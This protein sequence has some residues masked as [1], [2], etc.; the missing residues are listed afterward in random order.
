VALYGLGG[1]LYMVVARH[2]IFRLGERGLV[3][4]GVSL[5]GFSTLA[6]AFAPHWIFASPA[7]LIGGFGFFMFHNTM[8]SNATQMVA[9]SRGTAV[10]LFASSL[11]LGQSLGV[12]LA[13]N[14]IDRVGS[15]AVVAMGGAMM[16]MLGFFF[17]QAL[18]RRDA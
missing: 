15:T 16:M 6:L 10:S 17:A 7:C 12:L 3:L 2:L 11:F 4:L 9:S 14:L 5:L 8:Q 1:V 13:A 18:R